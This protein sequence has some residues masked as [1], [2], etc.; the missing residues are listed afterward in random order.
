MIIRAQS[1][2]Q[3]MKS[4]FPKRE[5]ED[6]VQYGCQ[7]GWPGLTYYRDTRHLYDKFS[8]EI[9][10]VL[11]EMDDGD[12]VLNLIAS[13]RGAGHAVSDTTFKNLL[14]WAVAEE[15]ARRLTEEKEEE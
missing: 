1:F 5:L 13:F 9:W 4:R 10:E 7:A 15:Y 14:V 8:D 2:L 12:D 6:I 11:C 3:W